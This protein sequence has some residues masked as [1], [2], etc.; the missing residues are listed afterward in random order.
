MQ[1][2]CSRYVPEISLIKDQTSNEVTRICSSKQLKNSYSYDNVE[3][4]SADQFFFIQ[5]V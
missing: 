1:I 2:I 5:M 3:L 4:G